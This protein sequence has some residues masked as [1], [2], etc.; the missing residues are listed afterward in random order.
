MHKF[1]YV[2]NGSL[3]SSERSL[4]IEMTY[5]CEDDGG[6]WDKFGFGGGDIQHRVNRC[7]AHLIQ[8]M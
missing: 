2:L 3:L 4:T 6:E 1:P 8:R 5:V 7:V